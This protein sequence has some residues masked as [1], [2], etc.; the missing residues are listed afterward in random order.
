MECANFSS[1]HADVD[2]HILALY[3]IKIM[4]SIMLLL[5]LLW[6]S[7]SL[8]ASRVSWS[9]RPNPKMDLNSKWM[10]VAGQRPGYAS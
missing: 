4:I 6:L 9:R 1:K 2:V 5:L 7:F 10:P 3:I 8:P